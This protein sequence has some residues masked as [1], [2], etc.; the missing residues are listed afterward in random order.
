VGTSAQR[1]TVPRTPEAARRSGKQLPLSPFPAVT[2]Y[3]LALNSQ[4]I[5]PPAYDDSYGYFP[6]DFDRIVAYDL[7]LGKQLWLVSAK[8][9]W[10][11]AAGGGFLFIYQTDSLSAYRASDGSIAWT[12][13]F[14]HKPVVAPLWDHGWLVVVTASDVFAFRDSDGGLVWQQPI[15][16]VRAVPSID[17]DRMYL[18][19]VDGRVL[20]L[21]LDTGARIWEQ[22]VGGDPNA[23]LARG[24]RLF[25]GS[26]DNFLY[27]LKT[28]DGSKDWRV[29]TGAD[30]VSQPIAEG[31]RVYFVSLDNVLR[32]VNH[33]NGVQLWKK[34]LPFRP[35]WP[36]L[37]VAD[38]V[39]VAGLAGSARAFFVKD[40][41][42]AG[43]LGIDAASEIAAPF[44]AFASTS[45]L[46]PMVIAVTNSF[47]EGAAVMAV[48][49]TIDPPIAPLAPFPGIIPVTVPKP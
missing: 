15:A 31:D 36:P 26:T 39:V 2:H 30:I 44:H 34:S 49:R 42:A 9:L 3:T 13:P 19:L 32:A 40:G 45:A 6:I 24:A 29:R 8:P 25:V 43:E 14:P 21:R 20:A 10:A 47:A 5:A 18:S 4:L 23:I 37:K 7:N 35:A 22:K 12:T 48:S 46:G 33:S 1:S 28:E 27:C 17:E 11:P 41:L 16:G 38:T